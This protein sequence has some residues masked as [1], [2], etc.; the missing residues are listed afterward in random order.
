[1]NYKLI[2]EVKLLKPNKNMQLYNNIN[3]SPMNKQEKFNKHE[4]KYHI[5]S[6]KKNYYNNK[7][8]INHKN[9]NITIKQSLLFEQNSNMNNNVVSEYTTFQ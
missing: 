3:K 6:N 1:M 8:Y 7:E 9:K 4:E 5:I 2:N